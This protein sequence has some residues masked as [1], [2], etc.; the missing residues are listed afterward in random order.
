M[1]RRRVLQPQR[2]PVKA[3]YEHFPKYA[4]TF[5]PEVADLCDLAG[6]PPDE[7][8]QLA[9]DALFGITSE[10]LPTTFEFWMI[11]ARQNLKTGFLKQAAL[12]W[13]FVTQE[14][15]ISWSAHE[16]DTTREAFRDLTFL[17]ENTPSLAKRLLPGP[18]NGIYRGSGL[19]AI[20][21]APTKACPQGQRVKFKARTKGGARGLTGSKVILDEGFAV[22]PE[23][24]GSIVPILSTK[25]AGQIVGG[26]SAGRSDSD[27]LRSVRDR[28][29]VGSSPRLGYVEYCAPEGVCEQP[30][31]THERG[32]SG[33]AADN[34]DYLQ[35]A[36]TALGRR[37]TVQYIRDE[38]EAL[39]PAE[40]VRE[41]LGWWDAPDLAEAPLISKA[42]WRD[43]IDPDS[44]PVDPVSFGVYVNKSQTQAAIGV[45]GYRSDGLYH[46]GIVPADRDEPGVASLPGTAWIPDRLLQLRDDWGPC[47]IVIDERSEAGALIPDLR[48]LGIEVVSTNATGMAQACGKTLSIVKGREL[49]HRGARPLQDSVI[50]GKRRD[51][52]DAWAWDRKDPDSDITQLVAVTLALHGLVVHGQPRQTEIWGFFS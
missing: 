39:P 45:A 20:E 9:L 34:L 33:C 8:Q 29:R 19:E 40:F 46:V 51:L 31:C 7:E 26:S 27:Y 4:E 25:P 10:G 50:A 41:R 38:R 43:L 11:A 16:L 48:K 2:Q 30:K 14:T 1:R 28:G 23:H 47:A 35:M 32:T 5:G 6:F 24:V 18:T 37:I 42:M 13:L 17:I 22:K 44:A 21:L 52:A 36:N 12:G 3:A 15:L 49:R